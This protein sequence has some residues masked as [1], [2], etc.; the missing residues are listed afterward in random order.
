MSKVSH[1]SYKCLNSQIKQEHIILKASGVQNSCTSRN[2]HR[3]GKRGIKWTLVSRNLL[4][5]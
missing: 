1:N 4:S 3:N 2:N 5:G